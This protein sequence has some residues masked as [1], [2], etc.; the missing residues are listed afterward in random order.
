MD[1]WHNLRII[2]W[3]KMSCCSREALSSYILGSSVGT[4][5]MRPLALFLSLSF[6]FGTQTMIETLV[7]QREKERRIWTMDGN[8]PKSVPFHLCSG[9]ASSTCWNNLLWWQVADTHLTCTFGHL[10]PTGRFSNRLS[11]ASTTSQKSQQLTPQD[12]ISVS[13][14]N[15]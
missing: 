12:K 13:F 6:N 14:Y 3:I 5:G 10:S 11:K 8:L 2:S 15:S 4:W 9:V 1:Q 7:R